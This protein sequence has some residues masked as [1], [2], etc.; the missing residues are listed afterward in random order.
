MKEYYA[1]LAQDEG[2]DSI[3]QFNHPGTMFGNFSD[4]NYWNPEADSRMHLVEVGN[5]EGQI[6]GS[7]YY[8]SYEQYTLALDKG[9]HLAPS[10]NQD[11][12]K[13]KWGNANDARDVLLLSRPRRRASTMRSATTVS[14]QRR[15]RTLSSA[16]RSMTCRWAPSLNRFPRC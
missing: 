7:G 4:F 5:G 16:I 6:G 12:H 10:N 14:T 3:S 2:K 9:W 15:I 13:A 11:N 1:L 8:P